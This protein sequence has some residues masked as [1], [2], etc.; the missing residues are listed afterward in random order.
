MEKF[1]IFLLQRNQPIEVL[2]TLVPSSQ[3]NDPEVKQAM[4][5]ELEKW[6]HFQAYE[7]VED[8]GQDRID[9]RW[10]VNRKEEHDGLKVNLKARYCLRGFKEDVKPRSDSPT[11]DRISTKLLY[12]IAGN[13]GWRLESIDVTA[14]FLQG[15]ELD[16]D[17]FVT[18]PKEA[19]MDGFLWKMKKAAYGLYDASRRWWMKVMEVMIELGGKTLVGDE[20][21]VCFHKD[22][23]LIGLI[24]LHVDDFQGA[25]NEYFFKNVMDIISQRFK[26]SKREVQSFR[27][28]GVDVAG[29]ENGDV[30][31]S[32]TSYA[33]S[34]E[35]IQVDSNDD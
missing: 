27:F 35:K 18:P 16:R 24:S 12:A 8:E 22:G 34:L 25:G 19:K 2:A 13:E 30:T 23:R 28:T 15:S 9:G 21:L 11:V 33:E 26:I 29:L 32:Q 1:G 20:S 14:A 5:E 17:I 3:F 31:I 7:V 4:E 6:N 10:I